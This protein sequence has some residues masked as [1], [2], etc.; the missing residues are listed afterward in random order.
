M[1]FTILVACSTSPR[2]EDYPP[3]VE[4][5]GIH[6]YIT[7]SAD[8]NALRVELLA[9]DDSSYIVLHRDRVVVA[10]FRTLASAR[11]DPIGTT[12]WTGASPSSD[13]RAQLKYA[14]R[15]PYGISPPLMARLLAKAG[16]QRPDDLT[17]R[18][19]R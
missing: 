5:G 15:F 16:Q 2:V 4:P 1:L 3:A 10:L 19:Q 12:T 11:F 8:G 9:V 6:G 7:A 14:S 18:A 17:M 13:H